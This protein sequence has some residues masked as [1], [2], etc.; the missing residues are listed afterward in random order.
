MMLS[1][2]AVNELPELYDNFDF[3][4]G[5][6]LAALQGYAGVHGAILSTRTAIA[7][8]TA[9]HLAFVD[10][11]LEIHANPKLTLVAL[12]SITLVGRYLYVLDNAL[13]T[14]INMPQL[15]YVGKFISVQRNAELHSLQLPTLREVLWTGGGGAVYVCHNH[16]QLHVLPT[17]T[18]AAAGK[19]CFVRNSHAG[20]LSEPTLCL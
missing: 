3:G 1:L 8:I 6:T 19:T 13:L 10:G 16:P 18:A 2:A 20:C 11:Q 7:S 17:I 9:P 15:C 4:R 5:G 12:P 14:T